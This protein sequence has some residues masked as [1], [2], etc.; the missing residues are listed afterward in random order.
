MA[1]TKNMLSISI[2]ML[3]KLKRWIK[4]K[5]RI[6]DTNSSK[7]YDPVYKRVNP[8]FKTFD[9]WG[10]EV[11]NKIIEY[12]I[13]DKISS[14]KL[15]DLGCGSGLFLKL[16]KD[17]GTKFS[18]TAVD[19]S[20]EALKRTKEREIKDLTIIKC[21][22]NKFSEQ[23]QKDTFDI[24]TSIGTHEHVYNYLD[25]FKEVNDILKAEG[26]FILALPEANNRAMIGI[27]TTFRF[28]GETIKKNGSLMCKVVVLC[29]FHRIL[30][31]G[32]GY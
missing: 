2:K 20:E 19:F 14:G 12:L 26:L 11:Y 21:D 16:L 25:S 6:R 22:L 24:A 13:K 27:T 9:E 7:Y 30:L 5:A 29:F 10:Y 1:R 15:I 3:H 32:I 8:K 28:D 31:E 23:F 17:Q 4:R 18:M